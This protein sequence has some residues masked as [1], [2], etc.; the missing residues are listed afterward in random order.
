MADTAFVILQCPVKNG[1]DG[2]SFFVEKKFSVL[3]N[4]PWYEIGFGQ[5]GPF[6]VVSALAGNITTSTPETLTIH[7][8]VLNL[9]VV[10]KN[11]STQFYDAKKSLKRGE[12]IAMTNPGKPLILKITDSNTGSFVEAKFIG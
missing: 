8:N 11:L 6:P 9:T 2:K 3:Q 7:S 5:T 10:Y 12:V 1:P 4:Q